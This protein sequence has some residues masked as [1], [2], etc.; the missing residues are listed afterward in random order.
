MP[1]KSHIGADSHP[2][3][4]N[5]GLLLLLACVAGTAAGAESDAMIPNAAETYAGVFAAAARPDNRIVDQ[6]GFANWG[7]PGW[8]VAYGRR[9]FVAG[10]LAGMKTNAAGIPRPIHGS[11][12]G[13]RRRNRSLAA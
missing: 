6:D 12:L 7:N 13:D 4:C 8:S 2:L 1:A 5:F 9:G 11:R 10:A 3:L